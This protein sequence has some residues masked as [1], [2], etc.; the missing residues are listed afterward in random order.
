MCVCIPQNWDK[1]KEGYVMKKLVSVLLM[2]A[3]L[4][5]GAAVLAECAHPNGAKVSDNSRHKQVNTVFRNIKNDTHDRFFDIE[6]VY[7]CG[8]CQSEYIVTETGCSETNEKHDFF[9]SSDAP[10]C[11]CGRKRPCES[12]T[13]DKDGVCTVCGYTCDHADS[14]KHGT[15]LNAV[16]TDLGN[17]VGHNA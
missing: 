4:C 10:K 5:G 6:W 7:Y 9:Y 11:N 14:T 15:R 1:R 12:H 17:T 8:D 3:L 2:L 13:Y 16:Y